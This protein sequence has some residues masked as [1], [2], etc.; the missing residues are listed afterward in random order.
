MVISD[1]EN[2]IRLGKDLYAKHVADADVEI[3]PMEE[4]F[5]VNNTGE[6]VGIGRAVL[7]GEEMLAFN[8]GVAV[9]IRKGVG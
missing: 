7:N 5:I 6:L 8:Y 9:K 1:V 3:R 2:E 4:V